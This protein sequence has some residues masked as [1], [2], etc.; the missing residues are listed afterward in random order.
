M[1]GPVNAG[2]TPKKETDRQANLTTASDPGV[3][4]RNRFLFRD[5]YWTVIAIFIPKVK[6][7]VQ[8]PL[9]VPV[10]AFANDTS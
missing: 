9:Y 10:G 7:G 4:L 6:C 8:Y 5:S 2:K 1:G 3:P